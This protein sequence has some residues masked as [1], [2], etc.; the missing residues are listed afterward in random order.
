MDSWLL[1]HVPR[2]N[3]LSSQVLNCLRSFVL[4]GVRGRVH[5]VELSLVR[6]VCV[7][8]LGMR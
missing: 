2:V 4:R 1:G 6:E 5:D 8:I 7:D 3:L